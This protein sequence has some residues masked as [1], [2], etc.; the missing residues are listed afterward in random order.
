LRT[1]AG[2]RRG[3]RGRRLRI[4][5]L[6]DAQG[7][8]ALTHVL[9]LAREARE[10]ADV[11]VV[12]FIPGPGQRVAED[13]GVPYELIPKYMPLDP[14]LVARLYIYLKRN[15]IDVMHTHTINSNF[16]GR[17]SARLAGVPVVTTMHSYMIDEL[18]GLE[19]SPLG[20][21]LFFQVDRLMSGF[22]KKFIAVSGGIRKRLIEQG[23]GEEKIETIPHGI[24][25]PEAGAGD[26]SSDIRREF[27]ISA[28]A[29]VVAIVGRM[30]PVKNHDHFLRAAA[31]VLKAKAD[32]RFLVVG[33]GALMGGL[34]RLAAE[35][36]MGDSVVFT[37]WRNDMDA[38]YSAM[39]I[40]VLCSST[41]SQ[42]LVLVEAM[43][44]EKAVVATDVD[45]ISKTVIHEKTGLLVRAG[46][47]QGLGKAILRL[48]SEPA[49][50]K[51]LAE[52]GRRF[53]EDRFSVHTMMENILRVYDMAARG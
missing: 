28:G 45:E 18:A 25:L 12:F 15:R 27:D 2:T 13:L 10:R 50:R 16:Y 11:R 29:P 7:G 47:E 37:G 33:D 19:K 8:G 51:R 4:A 30:V 41:E 22:T 42:G 46:D 40:L 35:L 17:L 21:R 38:V 32:A 53:V 31:G 44:H 9:T 3:G 36:G 26:E 1:R 39:D 24:L 43:A 5:C 6:I 20:A 49:L 52:E 34:K 23:V 48:L 14:A